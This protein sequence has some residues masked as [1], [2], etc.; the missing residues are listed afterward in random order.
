[1]AEPIRNPEPFPNQELETERERLSGDIARTPDD[2]GI[3]ASEAAEEQIPQP[4]PRAK[5]V[6]LRQAAGQK[7]QEVKERASEL[8]E[9]AQQRGSEVLSDAKDRVSEAYSRTEEAVTDAL[10]Q[11]KQKASEAVQR[12]RSRAQYYANEY[13]L[14][15]IAA[16]AGFGLLVG[17]VLRIWRSSRYERD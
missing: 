7:A 2:P 6:E 15:V 8:L 14:H 11:G 16:A 12:A 3:L 5:V 1:M 17:V 9:Q 10:Q 13:P 4:Q